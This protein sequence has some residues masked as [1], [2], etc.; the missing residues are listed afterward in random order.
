MENFVFC[1]VSQSWAH[2]THDQFHSIANRLKS[3]NCLFS[4]PWFLWKKWVFLK[5][6]RNIL[7]FFLCNCKGTISQYHLC[8]FKLI[9]LLIQCTIFPL[10]QLAQRRCHNF[11]AR[12][13]IRVV[14]TSVSDVVTTSL[15]D[16]I[17]TLPQRCCDVTTTLIN[18]FLGHFAT[19]YSDFFTF[20]ESWKS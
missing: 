5:I 6:G 17:K 19:D 1:A 3:K 4:Q 10:T 14:P 7:L 20:I 16:V 11:V 8:K 9:N 2:V 12:S 13:K 15:S 18:G